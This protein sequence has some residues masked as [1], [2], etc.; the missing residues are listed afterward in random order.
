VEH[1]NHRHHRTVADLIADRTRREGHRPLLT[2]YDDMTGARTELSYATLDN[3]AAKTANMLAEEY[4]VGAGATV[5]LDLDGHWTAVAIM[6]ACWKLG[7]VPR[8]QPTP[9]GEHQFSPMTGE[10]ALVC[11][12]ERRVE[13]Y[14][15]G[16]VLVV[17][18][19]LAAEPVTDVPTRDGLLLF[20]AE[21]HA[22]ADE[23]DGEVGPT[24]PAS[25][26][27]D[28]ASLLARAAAWR[29]ALG[30]GPRVGLAAPADHPRAVDLLAG[31]LLAHGSLVV[32]RP[33]TGRPRWDRWSTERVSV[34]VGP[35]PDT[36]DAPA[37]VI[38]LGFDTVPSPA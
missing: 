4:D 32:E 8:P 38:R 24:T 9:N 17:G 11:C 28:H 14:P 33:A 30:D 29:A 26:T 12:H 34:V 16:P 10:A 31:V 27:D 18:D 25:A 1:A 3:W 20:G 37:E 13:R 15:N 22:F 19:G 7:A 35:D 5:A 6:L 21:V 23:Y 2:Y 36:A